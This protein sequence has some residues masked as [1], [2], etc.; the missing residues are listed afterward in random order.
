VILSHLNPARNVPRILKEGLNPFFAA[1]TL[2]VVWLSADPTPALYRHIAR[3]HGVQVEELALLTVN[4]PDGW[5]R[6]FPLALAHR[7]TAYVTG[8]IIPPSYLAEEKI[9]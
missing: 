4:V 5:L 9:S 1:G 8:R 6:R 3:R 2:M 7:A